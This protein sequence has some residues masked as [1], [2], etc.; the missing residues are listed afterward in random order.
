MEIKYNIPNKDVIM[1]KVMI[2][3]YS[4]VTPKF[5]HSLAG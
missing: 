4:E 5:P 3:L 1:N 2:T